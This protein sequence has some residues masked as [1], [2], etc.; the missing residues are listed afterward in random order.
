MWK[1]KTNRNTIFPVKGVFP[2]GIFQNSGI[3]YISRCIKTISLATGTNK[4]DLNWFYFSVSLSE[5]NVAERK[6]RTKEET[7]HSDW[8]INTPSSMFSPMFNPAATLPHI[9]FLQGNFCLTMPKLF[10][11][12]HS[13]CP[14]LKF[15]IRNVLLWLLNQIINVSY[16]AGSWLYCRFL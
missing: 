9:I 5:Q 14:T 4:K 6:R 2:S 10:L 3:F 1:N 12:S 11:I 16:M 15:N 7:C 13:F 8:L